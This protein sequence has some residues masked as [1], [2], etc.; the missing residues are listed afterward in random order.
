MTG[1]P[2]VIEHAWLVVPDMWFW[3]NSDIDRVY[4]ALLAFECHLDTCQAAR[5]KS[6]NKI[7]VATSGF[8]RSSWLKVIPYRK[9]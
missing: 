3:P 4:Q 9:K 8:A 5:A 2:E 1:K 6:K 7:P